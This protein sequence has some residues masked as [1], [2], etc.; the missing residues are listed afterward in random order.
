MTEIRVPAMSL[1][2]LV[3]ISGS[4]KSSFAARHFKPTQV[5]SSDFC[6]GLVSDDDND[7]ASTPD[8]FDVLNYIVATRLRRGLLTVVDATNVQCEARR[9]LVE[10]AKQH[11][12][13]VDAV[14]LDVDETVAVQ[15]NATRP[16]RDFGAHVIPK[17]Q[18]ELRRGMRR[19][20]REG[21]RRVHVLSPTDI[22]SARFVLEPAWTDKTEL[23]G[24]FDIIG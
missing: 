11:H 8:A 16:D 7:Q 23:T 22:G 21:F 6:R 1:I 3:G 13:L 10:L 4:G 24:P 17:Q 19:I 15:R 5:I 20:N 12:V 2:V 18:R 14:V 9:K